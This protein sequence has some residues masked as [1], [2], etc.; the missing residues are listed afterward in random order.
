MEHWKSIKHIMRYLNGTRNYGLLYDKEKVTDF[1]GYS[2]ADWDGDL[3]NRRSTSGYVFKLSRAAVSWRSKKQS[4]VALSRAEA[5]YMALARATQEA[6]WMQR[7]QNDLNEAS[8]KSTLIYEDNQ[9]TICMAKNPQHY[10]RAK[11]IVIKFHYIREQV[12]K[13]AFQLEYCES[14]NMVVDMLTKALLSS[15]FV[16][17]R[18][19]LWVREIIE[20]VWLQVRRSVE[21]H[22]RK[23]Y[24]SFNFKGLNQQIPN[25]FGYNNVLF[26]LW[27]VAAYCRHFVLFWAPNPSFLWPHFILLF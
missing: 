14:K 20:Q 24:V 6:V 3:D 18:E 10:G 2:D 25:I 15:Q 9:S 26:S 16:K 22:F 17:P 5:E 7:L 11:H 21:I 4:C 12:E 23:R 8:A 1:I 27:P 13:K 19:M